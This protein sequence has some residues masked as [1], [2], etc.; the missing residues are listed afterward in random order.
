MRPKYIDKPVK[1]TRVETSHIS[2]VVP[3]YNESRVLSEFQARLKAVLD[4]QP[5]SFEVIFVDD[6]STDETREILDGL[7]QDDDRVA[8]V[9]LSR[10]F[11]KEIAMT[12]GLDHAHGDAVVIIDADLQDPPELIPSLIEEWRNGYDVVYAKRRTRPG[13]TWLKR[14]TAAAF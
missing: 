8:V 12:A 1:D 5:L 10:N 13:E 7:Q 4:N 11:G 3:A 6:G 14:A 9:R 2:I